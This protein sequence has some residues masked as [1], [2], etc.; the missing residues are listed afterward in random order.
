MTVAVIYPVKGAAATPG[1]PGAFLHDGDGHQMHGA[2]LMARIR[3]YPRPGTSILLRPA[4]GAQ[5]AAAGEAR[6]GAGPLEAVDRAHGE[7]LR[8]SR[9]GHDVRGGEWLGEAG[10]QQAQQVGRRVDPSC[11]HDVE[12]AAVESPPRPRVAVSGAFGDRP[13]DLLLAD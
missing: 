3:S 2:L 7:P 9:R 12:Q 6:D 5:P 11:L 8:A 10:R 13:P 1:S 4:V